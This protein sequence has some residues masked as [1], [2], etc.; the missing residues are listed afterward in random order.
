MK[1]IFLLSIIVS[2]SSCWL[3]LKPDENYYSYQKVWGQK[4]IYSATADAK[5][6]NYIDSAYAVTRPGNIYALG[7][8]I[9]QLEIG[10][11]IHVI[12]NAIPSQA[13]R[14]G[15]IQ[16]NGSSQI[17]IKDG[18]LYTN[19]YD[20]L[21]VIDISNPA[22]LNV[23]K[24]IPDAFSEGLTNYPL[25]EP[26]ESGYYECPRYDSVVVGWRMDSVYSSC[27]KAQ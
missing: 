26:V 21:V 12:N 4:P 27:Y 8:R 16:V 24:R 6:I 1:I 11:G 17:S 18:I 23:V 22:T 2:F 25:I 5:A 9:Y 10:R 19:S 7:S 20:E 13:Q 15:F 14:I 3:K